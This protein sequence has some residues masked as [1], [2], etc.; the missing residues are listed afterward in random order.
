MISTLGA[1]ATP[2]ITSALN[3]MPMPTITSVEKA[4]PAPPTAA[5]IGHV[6]QDEEMLVPPQAHD[7]VADLMGPR[8]VV[9]ADCPHVPGRC[10]CRLSVR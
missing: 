7:F 3:V 2:W 4:V 1:V 5:P 9:V 8:H 6:L 10:H